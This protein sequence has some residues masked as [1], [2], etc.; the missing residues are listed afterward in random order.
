MKVGERGGKR[1]D[2]ETVKKGDERLLTLAG[3][4]GLNSISK[5]RGFRIGGIIFLF[6]V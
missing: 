3:G 2:E 1:G 5:R 4:R 6:Q